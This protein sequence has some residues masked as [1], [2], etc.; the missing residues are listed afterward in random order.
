MIWELEE[1]KKGAKAELQ[2]REEEWRASLNLLVEHS[3]EMKLKLDEL[4]KSTVSLTADRDQVHTPIPSP[5]LI[6]FF[7]LQCQ[8]KQS[9]TKMFQTFFRSDAFYE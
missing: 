2:A 7:W 4:N 6:F 9:R 1:A 3:E 8:Q 5:Q